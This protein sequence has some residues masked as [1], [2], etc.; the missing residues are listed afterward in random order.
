MTNNCH[1]ALKTKKISVYL[2]TT[3]EPYPT[4]QLYDMSKKTVLSFTAYTL[5]ISSPNADQFS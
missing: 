3:F 1:Y 4:I 5:H 2:I